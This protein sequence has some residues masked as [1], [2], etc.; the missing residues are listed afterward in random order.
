[1][2][3]I[4]NAADEPREQR[5][6]AALFGGQLWRQLANPGRPVAERGARSRS[7]VRATTRAQQVITNPAHEEWAAP[8]GVVT[9]L[10]DVFA[11]DPDRV[12][13]HS[14]GAIVSPAG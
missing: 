12:A 11:G 9:G 14:R 5:S 3:G 1:M 2:M 10:G 6:N 13:I 7:M 8:V 4:G